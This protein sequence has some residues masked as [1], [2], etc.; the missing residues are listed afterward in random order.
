MGVLPAWVDSVV[1][2]V[3]MIDKIQIITHN[4]KLTFRADAYDAEAANKPKK[5]GLARAI[6]GNRR[7][8]SGSDC[9]HFNERRLR[10]GEHQPDCRG[11]RRQ[12]W[13]AVPVFPEQGGAGG[14]GHR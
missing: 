6:A 14:G 11:G 8:A 5:I 2:C 10:P 3:F 9:S 4:C 1:T 7:C 13:F 12:Y